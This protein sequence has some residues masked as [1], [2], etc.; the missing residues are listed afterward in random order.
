[1]GYIGEISGEVEEYLMRKEE[2]ILRLEELPEEIREMMM[3]SH[4]SEDMRYE[5][6]E[7]ERPRTYPRYE[8]NPNIY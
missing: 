5:V 8:Y 4:L 2:K 3:G 6:V 1:M 7:N